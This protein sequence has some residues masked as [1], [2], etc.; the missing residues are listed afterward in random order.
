[1]IA[2][3]WHIPGQVVNGKKRAIVRFFDIDAFPASDVG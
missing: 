2:S 1:L 3:I